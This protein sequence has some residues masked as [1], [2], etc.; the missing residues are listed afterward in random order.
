MTFS[1]A[2]QVAQMVV[3]RASGF[4]FDHQIR[5]S[6]WEPPAQKLEH[7][8][9]DLG[10][11]GVILVDGSAAELAIRTQLLQSWAKFPLLV[12]ADVEEGVGQRF[13]GATWFPPLMA[14]GALADQSRSQAEFYAEKMGAITAQEALMVGLNWV[15]APVVDVNNNPKNPVINVRSFGETPERVSNLATAFIRGCQGYPVLTTAK[16]FPGHGDTAIDSHLELPVIPH[17]DQRLAE[18][19]LPPFVASIAAGVDSVMMAHLLIPAWDS[20]NP[21]TLSPVIVQE[22]LRQ[23]LGFQGLVVT[24][25]L[26]MG[27][28]A[29]LYTPEEA[30]ILAVEAGADVL[31]MPLDPQVTIDAVCTAVKEGRISRERIEASVQRIRQAKAKVFPDWQPN[32]P[33]SPPS[34]DPQ[35]LFYSLSQPSSQVLVQTILQDSLK[36]GGTL[37]LVV[38]NPPQPCR[39]L[40]IVDDLLN[41]SILGNHTPAIAR[42]TQFGYRLQ[43][44]DCHDQEFSDLEQSSEPTLLQ[45]FIR[46]NAF[47]D[48]SGLTQIAQNWLNI[49]LKQDHLQALV[50]YGSPYTLEQFLPQISP[51]TPYVF[52]YGQTPA[53]QEIALKVLWGI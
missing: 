38:L 20:K 33:Y 25:A 17:S 11:G 48:S 47:R 36:Q 44:I 16:H 42:P 29:K 43:L 15:L 31:L 30:A 19:E 6:L 37:P 24:D 46:A 34:H 40:V 7:W 52:S 35:K 2:E 22:Q 26:V 4:L 23:R 39:N 9:Y 14:I 49:L 18:V 32:T 1:L 27:A 41:C 53:A 10:V 50:I 51:K 3:V 8:L 28:I 45:I 5:Y 21:A 12:A 13:A